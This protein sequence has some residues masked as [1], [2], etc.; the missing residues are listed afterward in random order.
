MSPPPRLTLSPLAF[1]L[2][3]AGALLLLV[4]VFWRDL[5]RSARPP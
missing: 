1:G 2:I 5:L 4:G 3:L